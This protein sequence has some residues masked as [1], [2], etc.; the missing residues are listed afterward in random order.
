[1]CAV[2]G[3]ALGKDEHSLKII[4]VGDGKVGFTLAEHLSQ[5]EHD[6]TVIDTN[7]EALRH[8]SDALDVM[9]VKGNG[10]SVSA[11]E[12]SGVH[13]AD[14]VIAATNLDEV[15]MVCCLTAKRLG[16]KFTIARVRN[17]E[18]ATQFSHLKDEFGIDLAI[19]PEHATAVEISRLLRFPAAA[20]IETFCRGRVELIGFR[21]RE[22]DFL[23]GV[24][25][26]A[27]GHKLQEL[28]MLLCAAER[29]DGEV[30]IPDGSFVPQ[31]GDHLYLVGDPVGLTAFF[32]LLG[33]HTPKSKDVLVVGGGRIAHYLAVILGKIGTHVKIIERN[34]DRCRHLSEVLPHTMIL[35]G[36]GT[37]QE[38]L[39]Q[40]NITA[41][42]AFVSLTDRDED[43]LIIS[44]YA[45]QNGVTKVVA[46]SNRQNYFGIANSAG[47]ESLVSPKL[48]TANQ[49]LKVVRGMQN[50]KG[51]VMT[52]LYRI[53]DGHAEAMEFIVG[54]NT[55]HLGAPLKDL[56]LKR[57]ILIALIV[58]EDSVII[59]E[60]SS[61]IQEGDTVFIVS[62]DHAILDVND[63]YDESFSWAE[64]ETV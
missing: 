10:A 15:N 47:L 24:P 34:M 2:C 3:D 19:N 38:M 33:R 21:V 52:S 20:N 45:I 13:S 61:S 25:L 62:R 42:D 39:E 27:Q 31:V 26:S 37:D 30:V 64:G 41:S 56:R 43:N 6:V 28:S 49:I 23:V 36:D 7:D 63:I 57:G 8:A 48:I 59:P 44:L 16:A 46:K 32:R 60:G 9:C 14:V 18:Y 35:C 22:G 4:I 55:R 12:E 54:P 1:M 50:S 11:L 53:A 51:S 5:E 17:V 40:E 29:E 58:R